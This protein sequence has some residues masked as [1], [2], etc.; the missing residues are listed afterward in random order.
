MRSPP[1]VPQ[2][3]TAGARRERVDGSGPLAV[4]IDIGTSSVKA[5]A[6]DE[7]GAIVA[8]ARVPH[9]IGI[10]AADR[11]DHGATVAGRDG[12]QAAL[13]ALALDAPPAGVSVCAMVPSLAAVDAAGH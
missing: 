8:Q 1:P 5:L 10:P 13:D 4:G 3:A 2:P 6:V 11:F 9:E 7:D 12:P